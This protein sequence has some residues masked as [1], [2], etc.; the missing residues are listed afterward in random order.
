MNRNCPPQMRRPRRRT[1]R[2]RAPG[3]AGF[4]VT[5]TAMILQVKT[6]VNKDFKDVVKFIPS[7]IPTISRYASVFAE[8]RINSAA[9]YYKSS[10]AMTDGG[11][12]LLAW[13]VAAS[14]SAVSFTDLQKY[15]PN[16]AFNINSDT[17]KNALVVPANLLGSRKAYSLKD[18]DS[19]YDKV[20]ANI[21]IA[22]STTVKSGI[23]G[24]VW[25]RYS[26][27]FLGQVG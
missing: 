1:R 24:Y 25:A 13:N 23:V 19:D 22:G 6:D 18:S 4:T 15:Q 7:N 3:G 10:S 9:I 26:I 17:E 8:Y 11:L 5:G 14:A 12:G 27:T 21:M 16:H 20:P 2:R